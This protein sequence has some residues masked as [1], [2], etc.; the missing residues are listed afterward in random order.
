MSANGMKPQFTDYEGYRKWRNEWKALY[1]DLSE[2]IRD[3]K[4]AVKNSM[5]KGNLGTAASA[6]HELIHQRAMARK[7]MSQLDDA[8][9]HWGNIRKAQQDLREQN[10]QFPMT[11]E[12]ASNIEFHFNKKSLEWSFLPMWTLKAKGK[13]YYVK[14]VECEAPWTTRERPDHPST[15]GSLRIKR[16]TI[17]I[18]A[19]GGATIR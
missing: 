14:H 19:D 2:R 18:D 8:R 7:T 10:A 5:R 12:N 17:H 4:R 6:Q 3:N 9:A 16:G 11:I 15:K 1:K 13:S